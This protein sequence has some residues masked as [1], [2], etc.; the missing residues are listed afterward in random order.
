MWFTGD[1]FRAFSNPGSPFTAHGY[2]SSPHMD[3]FSDNAHHR[4]HHFHHKPQ[5][6][7]LSHFAS[8]TSETDVDTV[9]DY[10]FTQRNP[11]FEQFPR[12]QLRLPGRSSRGLRTDDIL[13]LPSTLTRI[14]ISL[15]DAHHALRNIRVAVAGDMRLRDVVKQVLS[16]DYWSDAR[17]YVKSRGEWIEAGSPTKVGGIVDLGHVAVN[18]RGEVEVRIVIGGNRVRVRREVRGPS[19]GWERGSVERMRVY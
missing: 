19:F 8:D 10:P 14:K 6:S 13:I 9:T 15:H 17:T 7:S 2:T 18:E 1:P 12:T 3:N 16:Q 11:D 4:R 5:H